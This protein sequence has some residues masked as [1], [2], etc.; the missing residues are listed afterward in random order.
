MHTLFLILVLVQSFED[1]Y[2]AAN[3]DMD[4]GRWADAAMKYELVLKDDPAHIPSR[5]NLAVCLTKLGDHRQAIDMY[6]RILEQDASIYE[7][8]I[9][10]GLLLEGSAATEQFEQA[11]ALRPDDAGPRLTLGMLYMRSNDVDKAYPHL[12]R[13]EQLGAETPE[14]FIA[15]SEAEHARNDDVRSRT[16]LERAGAIDPSNLNVRRQ[17]GIVYRESGEFAKAIEMFKEIPEARLELALSYFDNRS[18]HDAALIFEQ[19]LQMEPRNVDVLYMLGK[20]YMEQKELPKAMLMLQRLIQLDPAYAD[21]YSA[22]G[23]I[24]YVREDWD[25]AARSFLR[26]VELKPGQAVAHYI[27][28]SSY[29]FLGNAKDAIVHYNKFLELDTGSS[30]VQSFQ[31][32]QRLK[33]LESRLNR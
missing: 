33:L 22:L 26:F 30:D 8:R 17:L 19:M 5:F 11:V 13:A 3:S 32:R 25:D 18:F 12:I 14:L 16:Y 31:A 24:Y 6:R 15:L 9:N 7:V 27:I 10:L 23:T 29:D 28:A 20:S 21:A 1:T 2:K 4:A